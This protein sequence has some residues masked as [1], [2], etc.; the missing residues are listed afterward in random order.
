MSDKEEYR[1][2]AYLLHAQINRALD[3]IQRSLVASEVPLFPAICAMAT[4]VHAYCQNN[5]A[6]KEVVESYLKT[7]AKATSVTATEV[8]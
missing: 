3:I 1:D 4:A 6:A 5:P 2:D 7:L 8:H